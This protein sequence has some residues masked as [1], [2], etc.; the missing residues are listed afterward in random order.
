MVVDLQ[1]KNFTYFQYFQQLNPKD[2]QTKGNTLDNSNIIMSITN[3]NRYTNSN[4]PRNDSNLDA[5]DNT[6]EKLNANF[7]VK[8]HK[9]K[10]LPKQIY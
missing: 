2:T 10:R 6:V 1:R 8:L 4:M 3:M 5:L 7:Q 9:R